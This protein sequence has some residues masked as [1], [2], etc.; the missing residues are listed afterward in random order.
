MFTLDL[1]QTSDNKSD[2]HNLQT[3]RSSRPSHVIQ[4]QPSQ[5]QTWIK[6]S[7]RHQVRPELN[8]AGNIPWTHGLFSISDDC[9]MCCYA[10][11]CWCCF[12]HEIS[13]MMGEHWCL[14]FL[15]MIPLAHLRTKF[16]QQYAIEVR[17]KSESSNFLLL[18]FRV[19]LA[20]IFVQ[21]HFVLYV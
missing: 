21:E 18:Y 13:T 2:D 19:P 1:P 9:N 15:N 8:W 20:K 5:S 17:F 10:F 12:R 4:H 7:P 3:G 16:R 6:S 14:W 11:S